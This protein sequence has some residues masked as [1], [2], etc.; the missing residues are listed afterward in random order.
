MIG[1]IAAAVLVGLM[2]VIGGVV[3]F[4]LLPLLFAS[5]AFL[6]MLVALAVVTV[7]V[8][9]HFVT[10]DDLKPDILALIKRETGR[11][12]TI[13]GRV[14]FSLWPVLGLEVKDIAIGNPAGFPD[15][16]M[17]SAEEL[18]LGVT[19]SS[20]L[21]KRLDVREVRLVGAQINLSRNEDGDGNWILTPKASAPASTPKKGEALS[22]QRL[23]IGKIDIRDTNLG[24]DQADGQGVDLQNIDLTFAMPNGGARAT[25]KGEADYRGQP[26][27]VDGEVMRLDRILS[28]GKG[29]IALTLDQ[30][31]ANHATFKG[32]AGMTT[33]EGAL[34]AHLGDPGSLMRMAGGAD[35]SALPFRRVGVKTAVSAS[36]PASLTLTQLALKLDDQV[37]TGTA[38]LKDRRVQGDLDV[39]ALDLDRWLQPAGKPASG[40]TRRDRRGGGGEEQDPLAFLSQGGAD[41]TLRLAGVIAKGLA[42]GPSTA[43]VRLQGGKLDASFTPASLLGGT[44]EGKLTLD[45]RNFAL[46]TRAEKLDVEALLTQL[47]GR[48]R[49]T[50]RGTLALTVRGP[51]KVRSVDALLSV[52]NGDGS[53]TVRDGALKGVNLAALVRRAKG[54]LSTKT[55]L[56]V[57]PEAES[58]SQET[59]F[60]ELS[61]TFRITDGVVRNEDLA[62]LSPLLRVTGKGS[63]ALPT[64]M[65]DYRIAAAL[66]ADLT[67]QGG[68]LERNGLVIPI[69][70]KGEIGNLRYQPD[71]QGLVLNNLGAVEQV[72]SLL[73]SAKPADVRDALKD[74]LGKNLKGRTSRAG[75][76]TSCGGCWAAREVS[77]GPEDHPGYSKSLIPLR[78]RRAHA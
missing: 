22:I 44:L 36:L 24:Y 41:V 74:G 48:A 15:P 18:A 17:L 11:E 71:L 19:P 33:L 4:S 76:A 49:V 1:L 51:S 75:R 40:N 45:R 26:V 37:V 38:S 27:K 60:T 7:M 67:G 73:K 62:M 52:L 10:L 6:L 56:A 8:L 34:D 2:G 61:G 13:G 59:D 21:G 69:L 70:V 58:T 39:S 47:S 63:V 25:L 72:G 23:D 46:T 9:P 43:R 57:E 65:V 50:G 68:L 35:P 78:L 42:F 5:G 29:E 31:S 66:V 77:N 3:I 14:G 64:R 54:L 16:V 53:F 12:V 30:G 28:G 20:L 55:L 32:T